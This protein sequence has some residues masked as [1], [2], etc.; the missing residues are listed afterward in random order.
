[1]EKCHSFHERDA[2]CQ[3]K[4]ISN[5]KRDDVQIVGKNKI[6]HLQANGTNL[7]DELSI[8]D[9]GISL[10]LFILYI[11]IYLIY[12]VAYI[13]NEYLSGQFWKIICVTLLEVSKNWVIW[14][15]QPQNEVKLF[16][17]Q[18]SFTVSQPM[19]SPPCYIP[20]SFILTNEP[21]TS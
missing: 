12:I 5:R 6:F 9:N 7:F 1:M 15:S 3:G 11:L 10:T 18:S 21:T 14:T 16:S 4:I 2:W 8:Y 20:Q 19:K 17:A 13:G